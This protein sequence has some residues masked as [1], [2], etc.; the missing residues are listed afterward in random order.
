MTI[1]FCE[2]FKDTQSIPADWKVPSTVFLQVCFG[3]FPL[4]F[5]RQ[6][7]SCRLELLS[8]PCPPPP[9]KRCE[10]KKV[11]RADSLGI[12]L[13]LHSFRDGGAPVIRCQGSSM[14]PVAAG[15]CAV[16]LEKPLFFLPYFNLKIYIF[17]W[18]IQR[19][20]SSICGTPLLP[21]PSLSLSLRGNAL[22]ECARWLIFHFDR[23][24][25]LLSI[26]WKET[27][28]AGFDRRRSK[29]KVNSS[30]PLK[31]PIWSEIQWNVQ[32]PH[33]TSVPR[34]AIELTQGKLF[35]I[36][37]NQVSPKNIQSHWKKKNRSNKFNGEN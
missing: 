5:N 6:R 12:D 31:K 16:R 9:S 13:A 36:S 35:V 29:P 30:R 14:D 10:T 2:I 11:R 33:F 22:V 3:F 34:L 15:R 21:R 8:P 20:E 17:F 23:P 27:I 7:S 19:D 24:V 1:F 28:P 37:L 32:H 26:R 4:L 25:F 18:K